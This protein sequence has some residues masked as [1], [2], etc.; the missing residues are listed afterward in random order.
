MQQPNYDDVVGFPPTA[1]GS[2]IKVLILGS[3]PSVASLQKQQY[4][5][6]PQNHFWP[7]MQ[8]LFDAG[9]EH[10]YEIRTQKLAQQGIAIWDVL[11]EC[12]RSGSLDSAI[13]ASSCQVNDFAGYFTAC[14]ELKFIALNGRFAEK[15]FRR[16][17]Q[18]PKHIDSAYLPSTSPANAGMTRS[19][20][21]KQ[22]QCLM[23]YV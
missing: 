1:I 22:W 9:P 14:P 21:C 17:V 19:D 23:Q 11:A 10:A 16:H 5:G 13:T 7:I 18:P 15:T 2:H 20:K 6:H 3:A 12:E 8:Q 4:Y